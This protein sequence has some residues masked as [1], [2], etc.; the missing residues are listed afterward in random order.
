M[1]KTTTIVL[2]STNQGKVREFS[3]LLCDPRLEVV[4]MATLVPRDFSVEETGATFAENAWL[5]ALAVCQV[6]GHCALAD[7]SGLV[8][9][10]LAGRPGVY[11]ARYAGPTASDAQNND[12]LLSE[13]EGVPARERTA[14]FVCCLAVARPTSHG[15]QRLAEAEGVIEGR[16]LTQPRGVGGFGYDPLFEPLERPGQSTAELSGEA[17]DQISHRG[18]AARDILRALQLW[19]DGQVDL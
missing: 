8:V 1:P 13:L 12:L 17:K 4:S 6:T 9:D 19:L 18:H 16:I 15:P 7:D 5:K 14:R 3:R 11:S 2:A 10:A